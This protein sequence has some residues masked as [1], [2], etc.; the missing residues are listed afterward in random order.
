MVKMVTT[1]LTIYADISI[2]SV[3]CGPVCI[4]I[5]F[6]CSHDFP[7]NFV[8]C[9]I[10]NIKIVL[11]IWSSGLQL[12]LEQHKFELSRSIENKS[13]CKWTCP[14]QSH[15]L[16]GQLCIF[17]SKNAGLFLMLPGSKLGA[18]KYQITWI[19]QPDRGDL[20][21]VSVPVKPNLYLLYPHSLIIVRQ[22]PN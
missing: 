18:L 12:T 4:I 20:K 2:V 3:T 22:G 19:P 10:L 5:S 6:V 17:S 8:E 9:W 1:V 13:S 7:S 21:P 14:V 15:L 16:E 11:P